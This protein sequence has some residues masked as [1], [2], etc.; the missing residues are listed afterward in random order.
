MR[1]CEYD[2]GRN[3]NHAHLSNQELGA[4]HRGIIRGLNLNGMKV[5]RRELES[6]MAAMEGMDLSDPA[7][8]VPLQRGVF[9]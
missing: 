7:H 8:P 9:E 4:G 2:G 3:G 6:W 1:G 5:R